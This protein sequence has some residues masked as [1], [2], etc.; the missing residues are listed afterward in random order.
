MADTA[1][2]LYGPTQLSNAAATIY[3]TPASTTTIV[4]YMTA[5]NTGLVSVSFTF[6]L[7]ADAAGTRIWQALSIGPG[8]TWEWK[9]FMVLT[10]TQTI[11]AFCST[12]TVLTLTVHGIQ[13]A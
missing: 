6:S 13:I 7:G 8:Q 9:G 2:R 4:R 10:A 11:Q 5:C 1:T 12:A 3:T